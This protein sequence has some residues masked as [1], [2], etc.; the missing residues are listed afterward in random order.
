[1][2][3]QCIKPTV[4][5]RGGK[6]HVWGCFVPPEPETSIEST[7]PLEASKLYEDNRKTKAGL[8]EWLLC[9]VASVLCNME[10]QEFLISHEALWLVFR[11][12]GL[13]RV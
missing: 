7:A 8:T 4:K 13:E 2:T 6:I 9:T 1:M 10:S 5:H 12:R 3:P 11:K